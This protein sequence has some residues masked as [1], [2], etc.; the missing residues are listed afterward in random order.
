MKNR[1]LLTYDDTFLKQHVTGLTGKMVVDKIE[2][3]ETKIKTIIPDEPVKPEVKVETP[4]KKQADIDINTTSPV[5]I[6]LIS[7]IKLEG[8]KPI[9]LTK[10]AF[11]KKAEKEVMLEHLLDK[12]RAKEQSGTI[13]ERI[14]ITTEDSVKFLNIPKTLTNQ[15]GFFYGCGTTIVIDGNEFKAIK[16][17]PV[18]RYLWVKCEGL[19]DHAKKYLN[20]P[21]FTYDEIQK[22]G[23]FVTDK[24]EQSRKRAWSHAEAFFRQV[25][26]IQS[27]VVTVFQP[28][29][30]VYKEVSAHNYLRKQLAELLPETKVVRGVL[31]DYVKKYEDKG[32][33]KIKID[34]K[35]STEELFQ[36]LVLTKEQHAELDIKRQGYGLDDDNIDYMEINVQTE[37]GYAQGIPQVYLGKS[38]HSIKSSYAGGDASTVAESN[39]TKSVSIWSKPEH[40]EAKA[41]INYNVLK[42]YESYSTIDDNGVM[43]EYDRYK[44]L[45]VDYELCSECG[46]PTRKDRAVCDNCNVDRAEIDIRLKVLELYAEA[47]RLSKKLGIELPENIFEILERLAIEESDYRNIDLAYYAYADTMPTMINTGNRRLPRFEVSDK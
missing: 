47:T 32:K 39:K 24:V 12:M 34:Y 26:V 42:A 1:L 41:Y 30:K 3:K 21:T 11:K 31:K 28:N 15:L 8:T 46:L 43:R 19:S 20:K 29:N 27:E 2:I 18:Y 4:N 10:Y 35:N 7:V 14:E 5:W 38:T 6:P 17:K 23:K 16:T 25:S 36:Q 22:Y 40:F 45:D 44:M 9:D 13:Y 33:L 37:N